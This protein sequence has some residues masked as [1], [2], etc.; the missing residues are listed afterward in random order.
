MNDSTSEVRSASSEM[1][2]GNKAIL[3]EVKELQNATLSMKDSMEKMRKDA[4]LINE[5]GTALTEVSSKM[6]ESINDIAL[7]IDQFQI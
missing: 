6:K 1:S 7:Q 5:S 3:E 2:E 4:G